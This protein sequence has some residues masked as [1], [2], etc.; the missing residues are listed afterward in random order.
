M[1]AEG[2]IAQTVIRH[3]VFGAAFQAPDN[4]IVKVRAAMTASWTVMHARHGYAV[5]GAAV[6]ASDYHVFL[7]HAIPPSVKLSLN[8]GSRIMRN[9]LP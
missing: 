3:A 2:T 9:F 5:F 7:G 8:I 4:H 6:L 1:S